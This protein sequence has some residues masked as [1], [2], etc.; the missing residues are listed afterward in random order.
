MINSIKGRNAK[1]LKIQLNRAEV[2]KDILIKNIYKEY[3]IYFQIV[4]KSL[5]TIAVK[6]I[7]GLYSD[8]SC[9]DEILNLRD[10]KKY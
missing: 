1:E 3:E 7:I 2:Q 9:G 6:G 8:L 5:F 4:R 10:L